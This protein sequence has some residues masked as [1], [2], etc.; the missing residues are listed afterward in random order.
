MV[1]R[2]RSLIRLSKRGRFF[3]L[4]YSALTEP[5]QVFR[6]VWEL[7]ADVNN[8]GF[9]GY[10]DNSAGDFAHL[11]PAALRTIGAH[12]AARIVERALDVFPSSWPSSVRNK[13]QGQIVALGSAAETRW[14][15]LDEEFWRYPDPLTDLL[16]RFV[17]RHRY[18]IAGTLVWPLPVA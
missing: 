4:P 6:V 7:E 1:D 14:A 16:Y 10:F 12:Q 9:L 18:R 5:E 8:G 13:R 17:A 2:N 11:A 3:A 15:G